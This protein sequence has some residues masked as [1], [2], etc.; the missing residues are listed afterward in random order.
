M[1]NSR[2]NCNW[3]L[4]EII[5]IGFFY[6]QVII[7]KYIYIFYLTIP[8]IARVSDYLSLILNY[9]CVKFY[10]SYYSLPST[11][12]SGNREHILAISEAEFDKIWPVQYQSNT[13][14]F[15]Q[16]S[17]GWL[18]HFFGRSNLSSIGQLKFVINTRLQWCR[19]S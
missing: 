3:A 1:M 8:C 2:F 12:L 7:A 18:K 4:C 10:S 17:S 15:L 6:S 14:R 11:R 5:T 19:V 13:N 16:W 9:N